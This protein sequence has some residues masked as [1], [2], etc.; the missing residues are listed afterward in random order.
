MY[1]SKCFKYLG[2]STCT[3]FFSVPNKPVWFKEPV[4]KKVTPFSTTVDAS[5]WTWKKGVLD[6]LIRTGRPKNSI[7][8]HKI[9][10]K[11]VVNIWYSYLG[12]FLSQGIQKFWQFRCYLRMP[13]YKILYVAISHIFMPLSLFLF[14]YSYWCR[15]FLRF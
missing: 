3:M 12:D 2:P 7:K 5:P 15:Y 11:L 6:T 14:S 1:V 4:R 10:R 9:I 8:F 13:S